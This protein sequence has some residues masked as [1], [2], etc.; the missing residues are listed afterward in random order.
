M[1]GPK[2]R[3]EFNN[4]ADPIECKLGPFAQIAAKRR[5][6]LDV[7]QTSDP[8]PALYGVWIELHGPQAGAG[9]SGP[10]RFDAWLQTLDTFDVVE[11]ADPADPQPAEATT[12]TSPSS[13]PT[14][15]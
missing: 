14:S 1:A 13:P 4:G 5:Y 3:L 12:V 6:G 7:V 9:E 8:E 15:D 10:A 2:I 11:V